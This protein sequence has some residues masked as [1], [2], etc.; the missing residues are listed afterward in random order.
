MLAVPESV[1]PGEGSPLPTCLPSPDPRVREP[2]LGTRCPPV[3]AQDSRAGCPFQSCSQDRCPPSPLPHSRWAQFQTPSLPLPAPLSAVLPEQSSPR[4]SFP[5]M[6]RKEKL[7]TLPRCLLLA[8]L[9]PQGSALGR[10]RGLAAPRPRQAWPRGPSAA[11]ALPNQ[12]QYRPPQPALG[13][14]CLR[15]PSLALSLSSRT[16]SLSRL[17]SVAQSQYQ[18]CGSQPVPPCLGLSGLSFSPPSSVPAL[19]PLSGFPRAACPSAQPRAPR[20][21]P[22]PCRGQPCSCPRAGPSPGSSGPRC[23]LSREAEG[24]LQLPGL[25]G[26]EGG[27]GHCS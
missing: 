1:C 7:M 18:S 17:W 6:K 15:L 8:H 3:T 26:H 22:V 4:A 9:Q 20:G 5:E 2:R 16:L 25:G 19:C 23:S 11:L 21:W 24:L 12:P 14:L 27:A 13:L 10:A